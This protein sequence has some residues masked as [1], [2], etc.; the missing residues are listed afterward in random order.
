MPKI[1]TFTGEISYKMKSGKL[2]ALSWGNVYETEEGNAQITEALEG[3]FSGKVKNFALPMC[4]E[5]TDFQKKVWQVLLEIPYGEVWTYKDVAE[6]INSHP[7]AVGSAVGKNPIPIVVPCH[8]V[9]GMGGKLT[10]FSGGEGVKTKDL[11]LKFE[12][13]NKG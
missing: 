9:V 5:G 11:L 12:I 10:G 1:H 7:R 8:R 4:L 6:R 2:S 3:F 13:K